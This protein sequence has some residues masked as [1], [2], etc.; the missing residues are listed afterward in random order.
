MKQVE[1]SLKGK[2]NPDF[3]DIAAE[4]LRKQLTVDESGLSATFDGIEYYDLGSITEEFLKK[5]KR[6]LA[7]KGNPAVAVSKQ[8]QPNKPT[9]K[10]DP[11]A[12]I[13]ERAKAALRQD[14]QR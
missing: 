14:L 3:A 9:V 1:D 11:N 13:L 8:T 6:F 2:V 5:E 10:I 12:S 7:P 4:K